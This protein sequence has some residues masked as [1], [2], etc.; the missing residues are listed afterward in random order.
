MKHIIKYLFIISIL[1][2]F[3]CKKSEIINPK[4][5][6]LL[7]NKVTNISNE[8]T[9]FSGEIIKNGIQQV[10]EYGFVWSIESKYLDRFESSQRLCIKSKLT[11]LNFSYKIEG[12]LINGKTYT[13]RSYIKTN[14]YLILGNPVNFVSKGCIGPE[15]KT[16]SPIIGAY[17]D[18]I[19]IKGKNFSYLPNCNSVYFGG[20]NANIIL[21]T[22]TL[23]QVITPLNKYNRV[24]I[25]LTTESITSTFEEYFTYY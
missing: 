24:I 6:V 13:V 19:T 21:T 7:T 18:T 4:Q 20:N 2:I 10:S 23:L 22:D 14:E 16:V 3:S 12:P 17:G 15:I 5:P 25:S 9:V 1:T 11:D 8:G